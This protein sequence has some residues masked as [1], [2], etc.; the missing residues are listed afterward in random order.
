M[1]ESQTASIFEQRW[2]LDNSTQKRKATVLIVHGL[3]EHCG[4]YTAIVEALNNAGYEVASI[5][6]PGHGRSGGKRGHIDT[7][8]DYQK[9]LLELSQKIRNEHPQTPLFLLGH[10]MGG[11]IASHMALDHQHLYNGILL[12]GASI[13]SP[14]QPPDWQI[15][16]ISFIAKIAPRLGLITLDVNGLCR[17]PEVV[18]R[19]AKDPLVNK[20]KLTASFISGMFAAMQ[21]T[22]SRAATIS[23]PILI[24]H[25]GSDVITDPAGSE[26]LFEA[27]SSTDKTLK[28]YEGL[29]HEIFNEP[30]AAAVFTD[31]INWLD[32]RC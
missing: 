11:L 25:G 16:S 30:E 17:D 1:K 18:E 29:Y 24:M 6:L 23:K 4:R 5:D 8:T 19:Y 10:S 12:S 26:L 31:V 14:Q 28:T 22:L 13:K 15:K 3:G 7:F 9:P 21:D 27:V 32:A 2:S 20:G